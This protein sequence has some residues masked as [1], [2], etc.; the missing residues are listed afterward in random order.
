MRSF[1]L[2]GAMTAVI[3][4]FAWWR[5]FWRLGWPP[6]TGLIMAVPI[7]NLVMLLYIAYTPWPIEEKMES[8]R[9]ELETRHGE[10]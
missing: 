3:G 5:I 8:I 9:K 10:R 2:F 4:A 6:Y 1:L 7:A